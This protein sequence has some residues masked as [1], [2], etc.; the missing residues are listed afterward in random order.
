MP[1]KKQ[2]ANKK[3]NETNPSASLHISQ[4]ISNLNPS[5][6]SLFLKDNS[7]DFLKA[8]NEDKNQVEDESK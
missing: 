4:D 7:G 3:L 6:Q 8:L 5:D 2:K 1:P